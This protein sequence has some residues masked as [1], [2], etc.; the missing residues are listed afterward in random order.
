MDIPAVKL[1]DEI[2]RGMAE[3]T[4]GQLR[5]CSLI[6]HPGERGRGRENALQAFFRRLV[7]PGFDVGSG[8]VIDQT[9][10]QS[11]QQDIVIYRRD[12]HPVLSVQ[13][14]NLFMVEAVAAVVEVKSKLDS[15]ELRGALTNSNSVKQLDRTGEGANYIVVGGAGG[16]RQANLVLN[17]GN[18]D[19]QIFSMIVASE[20]SLPRS[21]VPVIQ[22]HLASSPRAHWVNMVVVANAW[23]LAYQLPEQLRSS[24]PRTNNMLAAGLRISE[25]AHE[26]NVEPLVDAAEQLWSF[27]RVTPL[28][29]V[30]PAR[31]FHGSSHVSKVYP[32]FEVESRG[33]V[34]PSTE[35]GQ[36]AVDDPAMTGQLPARTYVASAVLEGPLVSE[37]DPL[38][39]LEAF[40]AT[41]L[42]VEP[43]EVVPFMLELEVQAHAV[44]AAIVWHEVQLFEMRMTLHSLQNHDGGSTEV[45]GIEII[46]RA[47]EERR[48]YRLREQVRVVK[49]ALVSRLNSLPP[50][51]RFTAIDRASESG[52]A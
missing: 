33:E 27:L 34:A 9:G 4:L 21:L 8:F 41:A 29:D 23:T 45:L 5:A 22:K 19:H 42:G 12:Y 17:P 24:M 47:L 44:D 48:L 20:A 14:V 51:E 16:Q 15:R 35:V 1:S 3:E 31:Y 36:R 43:S 10:K 49:D 18:H 30:R 28:I 37:A 38:P 40:A 6:S 32:L 13:G 7:P 39:L 52:S 26:G 46:D 25:K 50:L 2:V 11:R